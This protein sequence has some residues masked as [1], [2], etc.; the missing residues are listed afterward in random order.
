MS[1]KFWKQRR[2]DVLGLAGAVASVL[3]AIATIG[4]FFMQSSPSLVTTRTELSTTAV[5][6][7]A[8]DGTAIDVA[9]PAAT[10]PTD[11]TVELCSEESGEFQR[12]HFHRSD[13]SLL[14]TEIDYR[15]D[16][17][18]VLEYRIDGTAWRYSRLDQDGKTV[19][20]QQTY[21]AAGTQVVDGWQKRQD[22]TLA[23]KVSTLADG[24]V[25]KVVFWTN[26]EK[27]FLKQHTDL[28][29][30]TVES[31]YWGEDGMLWLRQ[32]AHLGSLDAPYEE[33]AYN[34]ITGKVE[35][36]T[37]RHDDGGADVSFYRLDGSLYFTR[38]Y[39]MHYSN[40]PSGDHGHVN[41]DATTVY[42]ADGKTT[43]LEIDW[44]WYLKP[45]SITVLNADG[46]KT[47]N[48]YGYNQ[49]LQGVEHY[50]PDDQVISKSETGADPALFQKLE[51]KMWE[52]DVPTAQ[53]FSD[54]LSKLVAV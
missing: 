23:W 21:D 3:V 12:R 51:W 11:P 48:R 34:H 6:L 2:W 41:L 30:R 37:R 35:Q 4:W 19:V 32:M 10:T 14:R 18:G 29:D 33:D 40:S 25:E 46:S 16:E 9:M 20:A 24:I 54:Q 53:N 52:K 31:W 15:N 5:A 36:A 13:G 42:A 43:A 28:K 50:G 17:R 45:Q 44:W 47:I 39:R 26:G 7:P 22:N 8:N 49:E 1:K 27:V 38:H